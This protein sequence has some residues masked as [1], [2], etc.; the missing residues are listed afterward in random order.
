VFVLYR[1][2]EVPRTRAALVLGIR[3]EIVEAMR[4]MASSPREFRTRESSIDRKSSGF[5]E[6]I[7]CAANAGAATMRNNC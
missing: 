6:E 3:D 5:V 2:L 4:T 7:L 1:G